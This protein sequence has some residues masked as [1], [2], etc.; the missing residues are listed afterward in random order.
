MFEAAKDRIYR[1]AW[2]AR[3]VED[4]EAVTHAASERVEDEGG[5]GGQGPWHDRMLP[6]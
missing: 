5:R 4:V 2:Q 3:G 6:M 1:A